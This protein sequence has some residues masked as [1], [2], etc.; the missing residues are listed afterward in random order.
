MGTNFDAL[1]HSSLSSRF[2]LPP[3]ISLSLSLCF[4]PSLSFSPALSL[5][6][7]R[8]PSSFPLSLS[9]SLSL[10]LYLY[11]SISLSL[12]LL[13]LRADQE[14]LDNFNGILQV[15]DGIMVARGDLGV[16]IPIQKVCMVCLVISWMFHISWYVSSSRGCFLFHG[17]SRHLVDVFLLRGMSHLVLVDVSYC[18]VCLISSRGVS[19]LLSC[20]SYR[21][22]P[23]SHTRTRQAQKM[24]IRKC[25]IVGAF[26][27][28]SVPFRSLSFTGPL[29]TFFLSATLP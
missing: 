8:F 2:S 17:M 16:E 11:L 18:M 25:N 7:P 4:S 3:S 24:M 28:L 23:H 22:L 1:V 21:S 9:L 10:S 27:Y 13:S 5:P 19:H 12:P 20:M 15:A 14:G 29:L 26:A 6:L